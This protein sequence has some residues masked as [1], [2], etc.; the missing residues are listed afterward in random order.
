MTDRLATLSD[1]G[2]SV[3]LDDLSRDRLTSG[4]LARLIADRH[5]VGVTSNP[6]T[7]AKALGGASDGASDSASD[8]GGD[9]SGEYTGQLIRLARR[10]ASV[11]EAVREITTDDVRSACDLL[12]RVWQ[13]TG[14]VDGRVSLEV[15]PGLAYDT[16][17]TVAEAVE[18]A[19]TVD[20]PN[21]MVKIPA[22]L[23]GLPAITR[24]LA[25]GI[26][27][28]VT[29]IFSPARYREVLRAFTAGLARA[30]ANGHDLS[31]IGSVGSFFV[32]RVDTEVDKRLERIGTEQALALRGTAAT[33][34]ARV[35]YAVYADVLRGPA[36]DE[37]A[38]AGARKQRP[39]WAS[40]GVKN[41]DYPDTKYVTE[42]VAPNVVNT[43]PESTIEAFA[44]HGEVRGDRVSGTEGVAAQAIRRLEAVGVDMP[45]VY[46]KLTDEGVAKFVTSWRELRHSVHRQL[47]NARN[48]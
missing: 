46:Q 6:T 8:G 23:A 27:V 25:A 18:L 17:A 34:N 13:R 14:G 42:L 36:W 39:L 15:D 4:N 19:K 2:V 41:P 30:Q 1:A 22:T 29:L 33:A 7:F 37:L 43:M 16:D 38:R 47:A 20:R 28:N 11:G 40:T 3:W 21:L 35:A 10:D 24:T 48:A 31:T 45:N 9:D 26:S 12:N 32:S 44:D 5:V